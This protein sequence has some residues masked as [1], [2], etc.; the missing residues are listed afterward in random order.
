MFDDKWN[1][2]PKHLYIYLGLWAKQWIYKNA[3]HQFFETLIRNDDNV[4]NLLFKL[5]L[6]H[7]YQFNQ[8]LTQCLIVLVQIIF[9]YIESCEQNQSTLSK[10]RCWIW[11]KWQ[12]FSLI[13]LQIKIELH[14]HKFFFFKNLYHS[15][16][17]KCA[18]SI[19]YLNLCIWFSGWP[20]FH[21]INRFS[22]YA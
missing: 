1:L 17:I 19:L 10:Y 11:Y 14:I 18:Q 22:G 12:I 16:V 7:I 2:P 8:F 13:S 5:C 20:D 6:M 9:V 4:Q 3:W 15:S 21:P